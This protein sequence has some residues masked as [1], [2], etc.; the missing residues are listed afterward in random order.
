MFF[1]YNFGKIKIDLDNILSLEETPL[2]ET[3]TLHV[4]ILIKSVL[5][6]HQNHYYYNI[7]VNKVFVTMSLKIMTKIF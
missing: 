1:S 7:I 2:E 3:L 4:V 5:Y 6:E